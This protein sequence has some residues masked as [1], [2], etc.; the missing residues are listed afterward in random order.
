MTILCLR[1]ILSQSSIYTPYIHH[2]YTIYTP[3][4]HRIY[5]T[6]TSYIHHIYSI[7]THHIYT[8]YIHHI[9][10]IYTSHI[11]N[12]YT[13][14]TPYIHTPHIHHIYTI[15]MYK[16]SWS[17]CIHSYIICLHVSLIK[18]RI[19]IDLKH[20]FAYQLLISSLILKS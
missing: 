3:H 10:T 1:A 2:I 16:N 13:I 4:I 11:H 15:L 6:Y 20:T 18:K 17:N 5:T 14:Y 9:Y 7:Y 12:I 8:T 19:T